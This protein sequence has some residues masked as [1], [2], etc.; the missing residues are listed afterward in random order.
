MAF[1]QK[2]RI[3]MF[4][5]NSVLWS[6]SFFLTKWQQCEIDFCYSLGKLHLRTNYSNLHRLAGY[7]ANVPF[8]FRFVQGNL[9]CGIPPSVA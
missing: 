7:L 5:K 4:E 1:G 9:K 6:V 3:V 2:L 8:D